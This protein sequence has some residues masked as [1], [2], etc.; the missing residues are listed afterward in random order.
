MHM[1]LQKGY[2]EQIQILD[3]DGELVDGIDPPDLSDETLLEMY[4]YMK[5]GRRFDERAVNLQRQGR[6]GTY[7]PH[8][9]Q[10]AAQVGSAA[11]L[12][13]TDWVFPY[14]RDRIATWMHGVN[15]SSNLLY[16]VGHPAGH[17]TGD[18]V[19]VFP[20]VVPVGTHL[21]HATGWAWGAK[22][23]GR[24]DIAAICYFGEG[25]TSEGDFHEGM[26]FAGVF[27][28]PA[29]FFCSNN[30]WAISVPF[31]RQTA[32]DTVAQ[33]AN[34]YGF[35]GVRVD[36]MDPLAV[37]KVTEAA[38]EKA[39]QPT[40]DEPKPTL[41]EADL[42]RF[43]AHTTADDDSVYR[44]PAEVEKW[45][46]RDPITRFEAYLE[47][48]GR[49]TTGDITDI[50]EDIETWLTD[51]V[52]TA[53]NTAPPDPDNIF[54]NT[55]AE[56]PDHLASQRQELQQLREQYGDENILDGEQ[57]WKNLIEPN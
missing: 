47:N 54:E 29:V 15:P 13:D 50:E 16:R 30:Q 55:Y 44:D 48:T 25:A 10:E 40:D 51:V 19:N 39:K 24:D 21:L 27:D 35:E 33:K 20:S 46:Q 12:A 49:L 23:D 22:L 4:R 9:G 17:G 34:A 32:S 26:N 45:R 56:L 5:F 6:I 38:L 11:A 53:E 28:V 36:G 43:G 1:L 2:D 7:S 37:Y 14:T 8:A 57:P 52:Q 41:I 18:G 3:P 42:Y 31:D